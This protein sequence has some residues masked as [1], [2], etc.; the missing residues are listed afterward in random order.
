MTGVWPPG[1]RASVGA[2]GPLAM[3]PM[4][5][6]APTERRVA[7]RRRALAVALEPCARALE[8]FA[9]APGVDVSS[10]V[11]AAPGVKDT[12]LIRA[13]LDAAHGA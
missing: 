4:R 5:A 12:A 7:R 1:P 2:H 9:G 13:F 6:I 8:R 10:G 3:Q 11:E